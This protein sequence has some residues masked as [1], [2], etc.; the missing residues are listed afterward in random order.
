MTAK[1]VPEVLGRTRRYGGLC[2]GRKKWI[3]AQTRKQWQRAVRSPCPHWGKR[4]W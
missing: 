4:G 1:K 3:Y 2:T